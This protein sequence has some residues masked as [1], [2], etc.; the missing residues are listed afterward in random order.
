MF[1]FGGTKALAW[2]LMVAFAV[3]EGFHHAHGAGSAVAA[4]S[5]QSDI[6]IGELCLNYLPGK[7]KVNS[8][9][10]FNSTTTPMS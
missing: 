4:A 1:S 9:L 10:A 3:K 7:R 8:S 2:M 5:V 6:Q